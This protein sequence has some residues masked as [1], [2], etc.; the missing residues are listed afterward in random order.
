[1]KICVF[2]S[3][4]KTGLHILRAALESGHQVTA[5]ARNPAKIPFT[6]KSLRVVQGDALDAGSVSDAIAGSEAVIS[7]LG[8]N[9]KAQART[10]YRSMSNILGAM[11]SQSVDRLVLTAG[12]GVG[13]ELDGFS[14][15]GSIMGGI[16]KLIA[17]SSWEDGVQTAQL[18]RDSSGIRWSMMRIPMLTDESAGGSAVRYG[19]LGKGSGQKLSR[20]DLAKILLDEI[21]QGRFIGKAP[22]VSN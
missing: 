5:F 13:D 19:Y 11:K 20:E 8:V 21:D 4:G 6:H 3:T 15:M 9:P 1:M 14:M 7:L 10:F 17:R 16:I 2:G 18:I 12:A 22:V